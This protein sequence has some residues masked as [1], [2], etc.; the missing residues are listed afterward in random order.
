MHQNSTNM[1]GTRNIGLLVIGA[2]V[3]LFV[4]WGCNGYNKIVKNDVAADKAWDNV[5]AEYQNRA[6]LVKNLVNTVQGAA[7]FERQTLTDVIEARA[8]A[9]S[10][11]LT[12]DQLTPENIA[13]FEQAQAQLSGALS[14]LLVTVER[15]PDLKANQNFLKLQDQLES[16]ENDIR[17][18]H[19]DF[20]EAIAD[21]NNSVRRFP[22][23]ILASIF[24]FDRREGFKA[25][26]GAETAP[27]VEF[28][29][30]K[31]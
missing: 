26:P 15:Y 3:L 23:S 7:D 2:I 9:T 14:R 25:T 18:S 11:N 1:K 16:I 30:N 20:N 13:K 24:G 21:Y 27:D 6:N 10:V 28:N 12:A 8:N 29:F 4:V 22:G 31:K 5:N 19:R 17:K